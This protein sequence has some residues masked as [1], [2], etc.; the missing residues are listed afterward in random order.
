MNW[1]L[2]I[3]VM[4]F[5]ITGTITCLLLG[6]TFFGV[7]VFDTRSPFFQFVIYSIIGSLSFILFHLERYREAIFILVLLFLF[8]I[9]W[10]GSKYPLTHT[11]AYLS[12]IIGMY[13]YSRY[14]FTQIQT[15]KYSRPLILASIF[16]ILFV[17]VTFILTLVY[18]ANQGKLLPFKNMPAGFLIGLGLG[19]GIELS[20][21]LIS[22]REGLKDIK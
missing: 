14:F 9:I 21:Y 6:V 8:G 12:V 11:L 7:E 15:I 2:F 1:K 4:I 20:E 19:M 16:A 10:L 5:S 22:Q 13:I 3:T 18:H 17:M